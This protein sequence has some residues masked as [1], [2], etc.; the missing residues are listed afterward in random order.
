MQQDIRISLLRVI[1][2]IPAAGLLAGK[3][4]ANLV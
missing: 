3:L 2:L 4:N 1:G